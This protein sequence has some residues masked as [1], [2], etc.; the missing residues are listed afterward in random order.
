MSQPAA[1]EQ[2]D[3][4]RFAELLLADTPLLDV[5]SP[6]EFQHGAFPAAVNI[7]LLTNSEREQVGK[8]YRH[9]GRAAA[10]ALGYTLVAGEA[11]TQRLHQ[12]LDF[13]RQHP[14][15]ALYC[16]RGGLRS[17]ITQQWLAEAG[18]SVP[19][20]TGGYKALRRFLMSTVS[21]ASRCYRFLVLG[22]RTG[23]GK[24]HL[25]NRFANSIDLEGLAAHRGS[26]FGRR[27]QEQP[28]QIDFENRLGVA[29]LRQARFE[30]D[31]LMLEDE[32]RAIGSVSIPLDFHQCMRDAPLAVI[33]EPLQFRADVILQDYIRSNFLAYKAADSRTYQAR[34]AGFLTDSLGKIQRRLGGQ[35]YSETLARMQSALAMDP[36]SAMLEAHRDWIILLL[37]HYYDPMYDYQLN[38]KL[39]RIVFRGDRAEFC[40]W[41]AHFN[42]PVGGPA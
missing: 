13:F 38:R 31:W 18:L 15:A 39:E 16:Y 9:S 27:V 12:W 10:I 11:R 8:T 17:R 24:T 37:R 14:D 33:D 36:E 34:F 4:E 21:Q 30:S 29:L 7:P 28:A 26:A 23:S 6:V 19:R 35:L 40:A 42:V 3:E 32:S 20:I 41:A 2:L 5:R 1:S 22:G 25:L